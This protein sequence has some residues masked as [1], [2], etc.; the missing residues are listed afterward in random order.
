MCTAAIMRG[1]RGREKVGEKDGR[2]VGV[3]DER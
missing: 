1:R 2:R 3:D